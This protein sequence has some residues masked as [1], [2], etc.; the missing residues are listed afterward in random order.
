MIYII[1]IL[2]ALIMAGAAF[3]ACFKPGKNDGICN[4]D[5]SE[6]GKK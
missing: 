2:I 3:C 6:D 5:N 1:L 4:Y